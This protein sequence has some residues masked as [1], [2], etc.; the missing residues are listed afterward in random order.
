MT[1]AT[2]EFME[3]DPMSFHLVP[4]G[5][6]DFPVLLAKALGDNIGEVSFEE[7][8]KSTPPADEWALK[9]VS[10]DDRRKDAQSGV[11]MANGDFPIPDEGHLTSAIGRLAD[12]TGDK[13]AA[14]AHIIKR[15][16]ALGD[17]DKLPEDW[18]VAKEASTDVGDNAEKNTVS[19]T[20]ADS[21]DTN[22]GNPAWE[23]KDAAL[24]DRAHALV[25]E[26][27]ELTQLLGDREKAEK[28]TP[29]F[30]PETEG[31][32]RRNAQALLDLLDSHQPTVSKEIDMEKDEL[33]KLLDE[34]EEAR[35]LEAREDLAKMLDERDA[36]A[37]DAAKVLKD[38]EAVKAAEDAKA[39]E[40][41]AK[42]VT[43]EAPEGGAGEAAKGAQAP[44]AAA[45]TATDLTVVTE[46]IKGLTDGLA[47]VAKTVEAIA[48]QD[49][50]RPTV[51]GAGIEAGATAVVRGQEAGNVSAFKALEDR[52]E[53]AKTPQE[54]ARLG[55]ELVKGK[56]IA[57]ERARAATPGIPGA[58][59][60]LFPPN[61]PA[62]R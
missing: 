35:R 59:V 34:R 33:I 5:A 29:F 46:A 26:A 8:C 60:A 9:F 6:S 55:Q 15:A 16:R 2:T 50:K 51:S 42:T 53:E 62:S 10:A 38:A 11:A 44:E 56:M 31:A 14:K 52:I 28:G 17:I 48:A 54:R 20:G 12:Y 24:A 18:R 30:S 58:P 27:A 19:M 61:P 57:S 47:D 36:K 43:T 32:I 49:A 23:H 22:P 37:A 3:L 4:E 7:A 40:E 13:T 45:G 25:S 21:P 1:D 39:A 41:A